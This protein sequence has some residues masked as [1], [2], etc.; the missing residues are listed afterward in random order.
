M[1]QIE[2]GNARFTVLS[3][4][5]IRAEWSTDGFIDAPSMVVAHRPTEETPISQTITGDTLTLKTPCIELSYHET[6][7]GFTASTLQ[8]KL[9]HPHGDQTWHFGQADPHNLRGTVRCLDGF[10]GR[11]IKD[12]NNMSDWD[13]AA[14]ELDLGFVS[15]SGWAVLDDSTSALL[16]KSSTTG[17]PWPSARPQAHVHDLYLSVFGHDYYQALKNAALFL[18]KQALVPRYALGLW[19]S[20]YF[21]F[22]DTD[23]ERLIT[24]FAQHQVP[25]DVFILDMDWHHP[26]WTG[27]TWDSALFPDPED[28][29]QFIRHKQIHTALNLHPAKGVAPHEAAYDEMCD[30]TGHD[31][32]THTNVPF[33]VLDEAYINAYFQILHHPWEDRGVSFWWMD[34]QQGQSS[35]VAGLDPLAWLNQLHYEDLKQ[36]FPQRRPMIF[37]RYGGPGS[38]RYPIGFS[39]DTH[40]HWESLAFQPYMTSNAANALYGCWSHDIGGHMGWG[41]DDP[42]MYVR[43]VQFGAF[44]PVF[45][46]HKTKTPDGHRLFWHYEAPYQ[47]PLI[48]AVHQRYHLLPYITS[49]LLHCYAADT[50]LC[51]PMYYEHPESAEAY[52]AKNQYYFGRHLLL[53]PICQPGN[54]VGLS[55]QSVWLP[56]GTWYDLCHGVKMKGGE[57]KTRHYF[58]D[59]VP[60]FVRPGTIIPAQGRTLRTAINSYPHLIIS[61]YPGADA[62]YSWQEDDGQ[63]RGYEKGEIASILISQQSQGTQRTITIRHVAGAFAGFSDQR[64]L[65]LKLPFTAPPRE[66]K[67]NGRSIPW[68]Y[69]AEESAWSF[70]GERFLV[71][72]EMGPISLREGVTVTLVEDAAEA[73]DPAY[74]GVLKTLRE[75]WQYA[76]LGGSHRVISPHQRL[77]PRLVQTGN[78]MSRNPAHVRD[79]YD[80]LLTSMTTLPAQFQAYFDAYLEKMGDFEGKV[81]LQL[82]ARQLIQHAAALS[83]EITEPHT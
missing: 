63:S 10:E 76:Q 15:P 3:A 49:E 67:V 24:E 44:S 73:M 21:E 81:H 64:Q 26:H 66:V 19:F 61:C 1:N 70:D 33:N 6:P 59:E 39:G 68:Q 11:Y 51:M 52:E 71:T 58:L 30:A 38:G 28:L 55:K 4:R 75:A 60:I 79:E 7:A 2:F 32:S 57:W 5:V 83:R 77:L 25:L 27:Y 69:R 14:G 62:S 20:R 8:A 23:V 50:S 17:K 65:T 22:T 34:W 36:R 45:R 35:E 13:H 9:T 31:R 42:E 40:I 29:L 37:S 78:R 48:A 12:K 80:Q 16:E 72:I 56:E 43:W 54:E 82:K 74:V 46:L 53:A 47:R 18:G 41:K